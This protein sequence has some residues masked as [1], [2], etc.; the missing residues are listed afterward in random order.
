MNYNKESCSNIGVDGE[1]MAEIKSINELL[2][3]DLDTEKNDD[4]PASLFW[5]ESM[6]KKHEDEMLTIL[7]PACGIEEQSQEKEVDA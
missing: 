3:M 4:K 1:S 2:K 7:K 6:Y 5:K